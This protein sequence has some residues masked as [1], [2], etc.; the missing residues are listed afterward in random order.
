MA[1]ASS[2]IALPRPLLYVEREAR[3]WSRLWRGSVF[4]G[5]VMPILFLGAMGLG[6][7]G[8]VE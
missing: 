5:L 6:L 7:G 2:T 4:S 3:V 1:F 8:L